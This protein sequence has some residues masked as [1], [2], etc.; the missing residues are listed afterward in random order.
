GVDASDLALPGAQ[1]ALAEAVFA[2]GK[3]VVTVVISG[4]P[5]AV[6]AVAEKSRALLWTFYPGPWGGQAIAE[7]LTGAAEPSGCL[8]VS[9]PRTTGQLPVYYNA[10]ASYDP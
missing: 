7:V 5:H 6:Q 10:R 2:A 9:V 4:R 8:P 3:P 1:N